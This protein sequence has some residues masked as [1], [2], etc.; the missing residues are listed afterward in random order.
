MSKPAAA[1]P[2]SAKPAAKK[3][4]GAGAVAICVIGA[5]GAVAMLP[6][7][8]IFAIGMIP[9]AVAYFVDT[10]HEK[11]LGRVVLCLNFAGLL[12]CLLRLWHQGHTVDNAIDIILQPMMAAMVLIPAAVGWVIHA[13][14][15]LLV[16]GVVRKKA[17]MRIRSLERNQQDLIEQWG[18]GVTGNTPKAEPVVAST[19]LNEN[20]EP[21]GTISA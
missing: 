2:P 17:E 11:S 21:A 8:I 4:F 7:T 13:Y 9:T 1:P 18:P 3:G 14:V 6:T 16:V 19:L 20:G 15:P 10:T 5:I 12:P